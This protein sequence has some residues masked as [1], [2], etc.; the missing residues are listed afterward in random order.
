MP[1]AKPG[2][3]PAHDMSIWLGAYQPRM[4]GLVG[5]AADGWIPS[6]PYRPCEWLS[7]ANKILDAAAVDAGRTP[8][9]VR[10]IYNIDG[11][12]TSTGTGFL[13]GPPRVR[14]EQ[15]TELSITEGISGY[16]R[17]RV[18]SGDAIRTFADEVAPA[19]RSAVSMKRNRQG[20]VG[21]D[22]CK[23]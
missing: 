16:V 15:L 2:P 14:V 20:K 11:E 13:Q 21:S 7:A 6:S 3:V 5:R 1:G 10:R 18:E 8:G 19:V 22:G 9:S 4:L 12:F 23:K 17:H